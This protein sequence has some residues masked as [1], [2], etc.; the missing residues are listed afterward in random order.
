MEQLIKKKLIETGNYTTQC[1][2]TMGVG[3][4]IGGLVAGPLGLVAGVGFGALGYI[5]ILGAVKLG[6]FLKQAYQSQKNLSSADAKEPLEAENNSSKADL[7]PGAVP[8]SY[9]TI[10]KAT[11]SRR[12]TNRADFIDPSQRGDSQTEKSDDEEDNFYYFT[13]GDIE[14]APLVKETRP[15]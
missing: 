6:R 1:F 14:D 9:G 15:R 12:A 8:D 2:A 10:L 7:F 3:G 13:E 4:V 5:P 11:G